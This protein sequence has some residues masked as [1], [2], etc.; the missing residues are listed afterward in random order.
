MIAGAVLEREFG[1]VRDHADYPN[2]RAYLLALE[3]PPSPTERLYTLALLLRSQDGRGY[4]IPADLLAKMMTRPGGE[5]RLAVTRGLVERKDEP[6]KALKTK[7]FES[8]RHDAYASAELRGLVYADTPPDELLKQPRDPLLGPMGYKA[9]LRA[10][11]HAEALD[12]L[13]AS[14]DRL[15]PDTAVDLL[16]AWLANPPP[17]TPQFHWKLEDS[18]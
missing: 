5:L 3:Q 9:L 8:I 18:D 14:F 11:R 17:A 10:R 2:Q 12:W 15:S 4:A 6:G 7:A 13:I 16:G 1:R